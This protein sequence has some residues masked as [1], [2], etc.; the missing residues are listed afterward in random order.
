MATRN[1]RNTNT[2]TA[3]V[4]DETLKF[5][6]TYADAKLA[7]ELA[8]AQKDHQDTAVAAKLEE[9]VQELHARFP[10]KWWEKDA[11]SA[12]ELAEVEAV[13]EPVA[14]LWMTEERMAAA[15]DAK[16]MENGYFVLRNESGV[17]EGLAIA[18]VGPTG[19]LEPGETLPKAHAERFL[20][21]G[22][23]ETFSVQKIRTF[24]SN[25][26]TAEWS[27]Y[28]R[29]ARDMAEAKRKEGMT[30]EQKRKESDANGLAT[31]I[32]KIDSIGG[33]SD[34]PDNYAKF[35]D[36]VIKLA[37]EHKVQFEKK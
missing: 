22:N 29:K 28:A 8:K 5:F 9:I 30:E 10:F 36:G 35:R 25:R 31:S 7:Q 16:A 15:Q 14:K 6:E 1:S 11:M 12:E 13:R 20:F 23:S 27:S 17:A 37:K 21:G 4:T 26:G 33:K 18:A 32:R 19:K 2:A 34:A 24:A 3:P